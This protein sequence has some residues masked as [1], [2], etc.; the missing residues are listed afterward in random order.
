MKNRRWLLLS[1]F[2]IVLAVTLFFG[3]R[4]VRRVF[5]APPSR[6]P[7]RGWM[8]LPYIARAYG[9]SPQMLHDALGL[10]PGVPDT[11]PLQEIAASTNRSIDE[12][13]AVV[14]KKIQELAPEPRHRRGRSLASTPEVTVVKATPTP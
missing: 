2:S 3:F 12:M 10:T 7:V 11:R 13:I 9:V 4:F 5:I 1:V 6:E 8:N 14:D